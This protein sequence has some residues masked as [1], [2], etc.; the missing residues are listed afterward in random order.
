MCHMS[1][2]AITG[3]VLLAALISATDARAQIAVTPVNV[4][5]IGV[6]PVVSPWFFGGSYGGGTADGN[7][8]FGASQVIRAMGDYNLETA[9]GMNNFEMARSR[10]IE[11]V[12]RW[13]Q[14]STQMAEYNQAY[15]VQK[16]ER[17]RHSPETLA[18]AAAS[19]L[20]RE[21]RADEL[22]KATG[23]IVW[24]E[25]L[26]GD[27]YAPLRHDLEEEFG[28]RAWSGRTPGITSR[29]HYDTRKMLELLRS[30]IETMPAA[31]FITAHKFIDA[32][33]YAAVAPGRPGRPSRPGLASR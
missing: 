22:D 3:A 19:D 4:G 13:A 18:Q 24:P 27:V 2:I 25:A 20:P 32:L 17:N 10:Y 7:F 33:D 8:M 14:V 26:M 31:D 29:I 21:L 11:N 5:G 23:S 9:Q 1:K 16:R 30:N 6:G 12:A 15:Q 28:L